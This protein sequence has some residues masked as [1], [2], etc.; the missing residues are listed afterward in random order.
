[1]AVSRARAVGSRRVRWRRLLADPRR[2]QRLTLVLVLGL[3]VGVVALL[4]RWPTLMPWGAITPVV[5]VAGLFLSPRWLALAYGITALFLIVAGIAVA[6]HK[7]TY[8]GAM[9]TLGVVM[10]LMYWVAAAR[11]RL[12][13]QGMVGETML[14]D[15]RD[16]LGRQGVITRVPQGWGAESALHSAYGGSFSGDFVVAATHADGRCLEVAVVDV[17]GRGSRAATRSLLL[18]GAMSGLLTALPAE[19]F[20]GAANDFLVRQQWR[21]GFA[22]AV[23]LVVNAT[24]DTITV[25]SAGHP[26]V[27]HFDASSATWNRVGAPRNRPL[28]IVADAPFTSCTRTMG[29]GDAVLV[30]TDGLVE[31]VEHGVD[32]GID[33]LLAGAGPDPD[34]GWTGL[35]SQ[36]CEKGTGG[37]TDDRAV[38]IV[39]RE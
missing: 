12:G 29:P 31:S 27:L 23:H 7:R 15:L 26:P 32:E 5:V 13:I 4:I 10:V 34:R 30:C 25:T 8:L 28:G 39:W 20:V 6:D 24:S 14:A 21:D 16:R 18:S 9:L 37:H 2:T 19:R 11:A 38:V 1:M 22:T 17:S 36:L 33:L 35:A 3:T